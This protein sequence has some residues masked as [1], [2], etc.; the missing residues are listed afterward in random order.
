[1]KDHLSIPKSCIYKNLGFCL[2]N[3]DS[4]KAYRFVTK[5]CADFISSDL[6]QSQVSKLWIPAKKIE[7]SAIDYKYQPNFEL[8]EV[9]Y[10]KNVFYWSE[11]SFIDIKRSLLKLCDI[12]KY[13]SD[14]NYSIQSHLWNIIL[15]YGSP[16]LIDLGDFKIGSDSNIVFDTLVSTVR[17]NCEDHHCPIHGSIWIKNYQYIIDNLYSIKPLLPSIKASEVASKIK[18]IFLEIK[19]NTQDHYWDSYPVQKNIPKDP[20]EIQSYAET[21]TGEKGLN[22][23]EAIKSERPKSLIDIGCSRGLY[24]IYASL[25][26]GSVCTG[27]DYSHHLI[28]SANENSRN[29]NLNNNFSFIDLLNFK[30]YGFNNAYESFLERFRCD[31]LIA[32]AVIHHLHGKGVDLDLIINQWCKITSSSI[33][34]EYIPNDTSGKFIDINVIKKVLK[35]NKFNNIK[36]KR[37]NTNERSWIL[38]NKL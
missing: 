37:S 8:F 4:K 9:E 5:E 14:N 30:K 15:Q 33:M 24:S 6:Y 28:A 34:I 38:A 32:P 21:A 17:P 19:V 31:M 10:I 7:Q 16:I 11:M 29:L 35:D 36:T 26:C 18:D 23:C 1:M 2:L 3:H 20:L 12:C 25:T 22:L 13:L 27:V